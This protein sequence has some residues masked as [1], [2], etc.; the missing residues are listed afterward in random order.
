MKWI[1]HRIRKLLVGVVI[2]SYA[3]VDFFFPALGRFYTNTIAVR[4]LQAVF[5]DKGENLVFEY[6]KWRKDNK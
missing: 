1:G 6:I 4:I 2:G 3:V 5:S